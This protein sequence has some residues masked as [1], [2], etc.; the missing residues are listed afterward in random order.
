MHLASHQNL[1][2]GHG[3]SCD[4]KK[5]FEGFKLPYL[6]L[7]DPRLIPVTQRAD[8]EI[9]GLFPVPCI[10]TNGQRRARGCH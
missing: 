7:V 5:K 4:I 9:N 3:P 1:K 8:R 2:L 10:S 6:R